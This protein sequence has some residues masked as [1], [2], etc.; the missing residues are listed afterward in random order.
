MKITA[1][2]LL[3]NFLQ[4]A[5]AAAPT[6]TVSPPQEYLAA[7]ASV[8]AESP[9]QTNGK[10]I[11]VTL[12]AYSSTPDQT[13]ETPF[14]TAA[15]TQV[16]DGI[17]AANFLPIGTKIQIPKLFGRKIFTVEDRM[18]SRFTDRIDIWFPERELA[19]EFGKREATVVVLES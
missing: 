3:L 6:E 4:I 7:L 9:F 10:A 12:T 15:N 13:D 17:V 16:R 1:I 8:S 19:K 14:L 18:H 2:A 11:R 5:I